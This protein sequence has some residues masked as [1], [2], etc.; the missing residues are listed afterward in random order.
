M[1]KTLLIGDEDAVRFQNTLNNFIADKNV[2][3]IKYTAFPIVTES[4]SNGA[5]KAVGAVDRALVIYE[6]D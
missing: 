4:Y 2:I 3:D 1:V 6:E 5:P